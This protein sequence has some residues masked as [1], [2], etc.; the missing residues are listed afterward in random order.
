MD[1]GRFLIGWIN[2]WDYAG[3]ITKQWRGGLGFGRE[4]KLAKVGSDLKL[5]QRPV[6]ALKNYRREEKKFTM[7]EIQ[8]GIV[9]EKNNAY[10]IL[11][12][13]N[14]ADK[15]DFVIVLANDND[16]I[17]LEILYDN[18]SKE[19]IV[20]KKSMNPA[21][22][23]NYAKHS[24]KLRADSDEELTIF[25]DDSTFTFFNKIGDIV[26]T[27]LLLSNSQ[28]RRLYVHPEFVVKPNVTRWLLA[29]CE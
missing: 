13:I 15:T 1:H 28:K 14:G 29:T 26:F 2:N 10:E 3:K 23:G 4:L 16:N 25:I 17:E 19:I 6:E 7:D 22:N 18:N 12:E 8:N 21:D 24:A 27:E 20:H 5:T 11:I 9:A